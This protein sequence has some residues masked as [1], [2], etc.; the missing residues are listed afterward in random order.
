MHDI[1][2]NMIQKYQNQEMQWEYLQGGK[3]YPSSSN[4]IFKTWYMV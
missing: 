4:P 3:S 1:I 2:I